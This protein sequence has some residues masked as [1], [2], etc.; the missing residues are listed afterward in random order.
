R[1]QG[2]RISSRLLDVGSIVSFAAREP[3]QIWAI[4][5]SLVLVPIGVIA[6]LILVMGL[7]VLSESALIS[8]RSWRLRD[9]AGRGNR[10]AAIALG[11]REDLDHFV[12]TVRLGISLVGTIAGVYAGTVVWRVRAA[13]GSGHPGFLAWLVLAGVV[14]AI[15]ALGFLVGRLLPRK[16]ALHEPERIA[17]WTAGPMFVFTRIVGPLAW[18]LESLTKLLAGLFGVESPARPAVTPEQIKGLLWEGTKAGVFE[19]AEHEIFKRVFRF[20]KRRARALMT[21]RDEVVWIDLA[22]PPEEIRRKVIS[23]PYSR[24][25]VC[26]ESLDNLLGIVQVKDLLAQ[27]SGGNSFRIKGL[28]TLPAFVYEGSRGPQVLEILKSSSTHTAVVLDEYGSVV[29]IL[30]LGDLLKAVLGDLPD[31]EGDDEAPRSVQALDGSWLL[32]GR[33]PLDEFRD[34]FN[35]AELPEEDYHTLAGFVV[36]QLGHIPRVAETFDSL[37]LRFEVAEMDAQRVTRVMVRPLGPM[38]SAR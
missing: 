27:N 16:F 25:P 20:C 1:S 4:G 14:V 17:C 31:R 34:L 12:S 37:G 23:T 24:F 21:P 29:G 19:Q 32:D 26:D 35:L 28:L 22:D 33:F 30:T 9:W 36:T 15:A 2:G 6:G 18:C 3:L 5:M 7:L 10:A 13:W 11:L 8:A 38:R